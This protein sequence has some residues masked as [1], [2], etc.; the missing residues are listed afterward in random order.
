VTKGETFGVVESVKVR[1]GRAADSSLP[2]QNERIR[3]QRP[4]PI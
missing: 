4:F 1:G 3:S 2:L